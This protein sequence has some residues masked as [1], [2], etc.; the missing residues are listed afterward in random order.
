MCELSAKQSA[1]V[2]AAEVAGIR[3]RMR[4]QENMSCQKF[5]VCESKL[6][7]ESTAAHALVEELKESQRRLPDAVANPGIHGRVPEDV[8]KLRQELMK[9]Q[10]ALAGSQAEK[11]IADSVRKNGI[12][13]W[14]SHR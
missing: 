12:G 1:E 13:L 9:A 7:A 11:N 6:H 3:Q 10:T 8:T 5:E 4:T 2:E 14:S